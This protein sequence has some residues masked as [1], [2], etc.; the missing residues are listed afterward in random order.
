MNVAIDYDNGIERTKTRPKLLA[1]K[2]ADESVE[3]A[4]IKLVQ[5]RARPVL[6]RRSVL[7]KP[8]ITVPRGESNPWRVSNPRPQ[9]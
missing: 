5:A 2:K 9:E 6:H 8:I 1:F 4:K 7:G 3:P